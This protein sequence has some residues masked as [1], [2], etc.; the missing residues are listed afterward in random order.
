MRPY[1]GSGRRVQSPMAWMCRIAGAGGEIDDDAVIAGQACRARQRVVRRGADP[2]QHGVAGQ[3]RAV[4]QAH[5]GDAARFAFDRRDAGAAQDAHV[6]GRV[7]AGEETPT[8]V[9]DATRASTRGLAF[10]DGHRD[11]E[12]AGGG[13]DLQPDIAAA[14]HHQPAARG[15]CRLQRVGVG[16]AA[17]RQHA[18]QVVAGDRQH[19]RPRAGCQDELVVAVA[20]RRSPA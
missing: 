7:R 20:V 4:C 9:R 3:R 6:V 8:A 2:D 5:A 11:A 10:D 19:A 12:G 16:H 17:Q 14:D 15:Q 1:S 13:G 18:G